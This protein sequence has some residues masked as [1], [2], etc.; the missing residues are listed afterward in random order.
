MSS[1]LTTNFPSF[2]VTKTATRQLITATVVMLIK[3]IKVISWICDINQAAPDLVL[4][5][6]NK[7]MNVNIMFAVLTPPKEVRK[8]FVL[9]FKIE[10]CNRGLKSNLKYQYQLWPKKPHKPR[11]AGAKK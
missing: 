7:D 5:N 3:S 6:V 10:F 2:N 8:S 4:S 9:D 11:T 1:L